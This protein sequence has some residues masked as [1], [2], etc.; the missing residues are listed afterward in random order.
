MCPSRS[1]VR[2]SLA[3]VGSRGCIST[4]RFNHW[5]MFAPKADGLKLALDGRP[6]RL[7]FTRHPP[8]F[9][10]RQRLEERAANGPAVHFRRVDVDHLDQFQMPTFFPET[11]EANRLDAPR[12]G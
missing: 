6:F 10:P 9:M 3:E 8:E 11:V 2:P 4:H 1:S 7:C 5:I 12:L